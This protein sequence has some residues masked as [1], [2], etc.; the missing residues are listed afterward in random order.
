MA[1]YESIA[2]YYEY[3]FPSNRA[4]RAF[5][6][7]SL[8]KQKGVR[9]LDIGCATGEFT[10]SLIESEMFSHIEAIDLDKEMIDIAKSKYENEKIKFRL[11]DMTAIKQH[12]GCNSFD[13]VTCFGNTLVHLSGLPQISKFLKDVKSLLKPGGKLLLQILNYKYIIDNKIYELPLIDNK[14]ISFERLYIEQ[15]DRLLFKTR[16]TIKG[17]NT[18]VN[19]EILLYPLRLK[20]L[21]ASLMKAGFTQLEIFAGFNGEKY[22]GNHIPLVVEAI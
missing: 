14:H 12:Y 10:F 2:G 22:S 7:K 5:V 20:E 6:F 13:A 8:G 19:N 3:I 9:L 16:L 15:E 11:M 17:K 1:F 21:E 18:I 4:K